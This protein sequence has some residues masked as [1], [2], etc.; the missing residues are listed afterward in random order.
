MKILNI[1]G[2]KKMYFYIIGLGGIGGNLAK[3]LG[4]LLAYNMDLE[5]KITL[6]DGDVVEFKN[7]TRQPYQGNEVNKSKASAL[8][9]KM[10]VVY[11]DLNLS[12]VDRFINTEEELLTIMQ[13][14]DDDVL[15][16]LVGCVDNHHARRVMHQ[17]FNT[18]STCLYI[19]CA[20]EKT[21]GEVIAGFRLAGEEIA[22]PRASIFPEILEDTSISKSEQGCQD[23]YKSTPQ[24]RG[25][26]LFAAVIAYTY[27][28]N[29]VVF[30]EVYAG[31][32]NFNTR[33]IYARTDLTM[34]G[35]IYDE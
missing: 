22:P 11:P 7:C 35:E 3:E 6:I 31:V 26:N 19:D 34:G 12:Y 10:G 9:Y 5:T 16:V 33:A 23:L 25:T 28:Q 30:K 29:L 1:E 14:D 15:P 18:L 4:P 32:T 13:C 8:A 20:N 24:L 21:Y 17:V 27:I 2:V